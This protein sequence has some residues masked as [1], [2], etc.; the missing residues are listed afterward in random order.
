M[1]V[2]VGVSLDKGGNVFISVSGFDIIQKV[3]MITG[4]I[5]TVAGTGDRGYGGDEGQAISAKLNGPRGASLDTSENIF[6]A[7]T[8]NHRI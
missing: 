6:I 5:T 8:R 4:I 2:P 1:Y 7:D 3:T